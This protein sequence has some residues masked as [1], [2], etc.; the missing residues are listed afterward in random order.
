MKEQEPDALDQLV[1]LSRRSPTTEPPAMRPG[2]ASR[3]SRIALGSSAPPEQEYD[4]LLSACKVALL[5]CVAVTLLM[6]AINGPS[7]ILSAWAPE[8]VFESRVSERVLLGE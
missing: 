3:V 7:V 6:I 4:H 1:A 2:F 8:A 5:A